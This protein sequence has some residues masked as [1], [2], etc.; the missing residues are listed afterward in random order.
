MCECRTT[1]IAVISRGE[2]R[3]GT[4]SN[5]ISSDCSLNSCPIWINCP[6]SRPISAQF[7]YGQ[8]R[9]KLKKLLFSL[10]HITVLYNLFFLGLRCY[11]EQF[12]KTHPKTSVF[13]V[14]TANKF[15]VYIKYCRGGGGA[16][17][18]LRGTLFWFFLV[19]EHRY[20]AS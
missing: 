14:K 15:I 11:F 12:W 8:C 16:Y 10:F 9:N 2:A 4:N 5:L 19:A 6:Y 17:Q 1:W 7:H 20:R 3:F 18:I 13:L